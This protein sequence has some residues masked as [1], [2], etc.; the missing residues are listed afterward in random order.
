M[1]SD[2]ES[3]PEKAAK[4]PEVPEKKAK[5]PESDSD[6]DSSSDSSSDSESEAEPKKEEA[7]TKPEPMEVDEDSSDTESSSS[8]DEAAPKPKPKEKPA[9]E[10]A[11]D[12]ADSDDSSDSSA[13]DSSESED[14]KT[15]AK[16]PEKKEDSSSSESSSEEEPEKKDAK[17]KTDDSDSSSS[18]DESEPEKEKEPPATPVK[19]NKRKSD[20]ED[21]SDPKRGKPNRNYFG[22]SKTEL[23][24][25][26]KRVFVGNLNYEIDDQ[27]IRE[28]FKDIGPIED[29][30]WLTNRDTG[31]FR[32]CGFL[33]FDT[34]E[35]ADKAV[36]E[37]TG[38][39]LLGRGL[40]IDWAEERGG[41]TKKSTKVP[42]WVNNPL[43]ERPDNCY[44]VFLGNLDFKIT[45]EDVK[46]HFK[47][48][49]EVTQIRW[50]SNKE[51]EFTGA[52]FAEFDTCEAVD[53]AV[54]HCGKE[55]IGRPARVDYAKARPPKD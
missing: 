20:F 37:K 53:K 16:K 11:A 44:T 48:C 35:A 46:A 28:F 45:D 15:E 40:K 47:E 49:G 41:G 4:K 22:A 21:G 43:S 23:K 36:L 54:K 24:G 7:K 14:V 27:K 26:T 17:K 51:G 3:E 10:K 2:D 34:F 8:D 32:G 29:I 9:P 38:K 25:T 33:R 18:S 30:Y 12:S 50:L 19:D 52:G 13:S 55:I 31:E 1:G 42:A 39:D 6:S 5:K